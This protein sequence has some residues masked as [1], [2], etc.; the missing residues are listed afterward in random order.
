MVNLI[1]SDSFDVTH[2][3]I[4]QS[5]S[6]L[7]I[8]VIL[9]EVVSTVLYISSCFLFAC[10]ISHSFFNITAVGF[11]VSKLILVVYLIY[12]W[13]T[14]Y[15]EIRPD[16]VVHRKGFFFQKEEKCPLKYVR[17]I[18]FEQSLAGRILNYGT[19]NL[20][21]WQTEHK[22]DLYMIHNPRKY[23]SLLNRLVPDTEQYQKHI[24][25]K[26]IYEDTKM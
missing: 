24:R 26:F 10:S 9:I 12:Q 11:S 25:E 21:D 13:L 3:N 14:E 23:L 19:I 5:I 18:E 7:I 17:E 22:H 1:K 4:R 2:I 15:Y 16:M 6:V 8:R 20:F